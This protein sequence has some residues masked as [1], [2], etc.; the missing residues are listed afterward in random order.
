MSGNATRKSKKAEIIKLLREGKTPSEI[1]NKL[2][3]TR[4][5]VSKIK[6]ELEL[7][8]FKS[9]GELE[10]AVFRR[11]EE[12]KSPVEVVMELQV[13]ADKVQEIYDKY[14]ELK[15]LPSVTIFELLDELEKRVGELERKLDRVG[16]IFLRFLREYYDEKAELKRQI[17]ETETTFRSRIKELSTVVVYLSV[18][19]ALNS[20]RNKYGPPAERVAFENAKRA[21]KVFLLSDPREV[22]VITLRN[23]LVAN[24]G[25]FMGLKNFKR[26]KLI[27]SL[28]NIINSQLAQ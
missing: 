5:Y 22:D 8:R 24:K 26:V 11:F 9:E 27:D 12:G 2:G 15:D 17:N 21:L 20:D 25:Y 4:S 28:L 19:H 7:G 14:L 13:P 6:K 1:E 10:A 18:Q 3:V 16:K 23:N